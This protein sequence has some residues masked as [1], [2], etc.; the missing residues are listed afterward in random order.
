MP[1]ILGPA[2]TASTKTVYR[3]SK[4]TYQIARVLGEICTHFAMLEWN[5]DRTIWA[6]TGHSRKTGR[7]TTLRLLNKARVRRLRDVAIARFGLSSPS[8][9]YYKKLADHIGRLIDDRNIY[10]HGIWC[11]GKKRGTRRQR[12]VITYFSNPLGDVYPV[13]LK[14]MRA[15]T[16]AIHRAAVDLERAAIDHLNARLP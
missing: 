14:K 1:A 6:L 3:P 12:F 5:V 16:R 8:Q 13:E 11:K 4:V 10:V 9:R 15:F 7:H 2:V